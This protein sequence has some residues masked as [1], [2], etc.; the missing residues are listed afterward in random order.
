MVLDQQGRQRTPGHRAVHARE[1]RGAPTGHGLAREGVGQRNHHTDRQ[2]LSRR[3]HHHDL[4]REDTAHQ[5]QKHGRLKPREHVAA[6]SGHRHERRTD[7]RCSRQDWPSD[8]AAATSN[9]AQGS[10][11]RDRGHRVRTKETSRWNKTDQGR[12]TRR[13]TRARGYTRAESMRNRGGGTGSCERR[14]SKEGEDT[15][16]EAE[17]RQKK[18]V[19]P[20]N[21]RRTNPA[22]TCVE[23][24]K[25]K[26]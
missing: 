13:A 23:Q 14:R 25:G 11:M 9:R 26:K 3:E 2:Q 7:R 15:I 4:G 1:S 5:K 18:N 6:S 22:L 16:V 10:R 12:V 21:L 17:T 19:K 8:C 24:N 20:K